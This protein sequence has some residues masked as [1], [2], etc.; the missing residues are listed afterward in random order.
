MRSH[1]RSIA[2]EAQF[3][4]SPSGLCGLNHD[5]FLLCSDGLTDMVDDSVIR[6]I[7]ASTGSLQQ[8]VKNLITAA[9]TAGGKDNITVI[10]CEME[11]K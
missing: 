1:P 8:K 4:N 6:D 11:W 5:I 9:M 2:P 3:G 7:L 10:L